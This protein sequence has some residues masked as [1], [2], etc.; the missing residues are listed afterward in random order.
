MADFML[1]D[2]Y[3]VLNAWPELVALK[4]NF[5][6]ARDKLVDILSDYGSYK[7]YNIIIV[8]DAHSIAGGSA[9]IEVVPGRLQV[10]FTKE[11]ETA[12]SYIEKLAYQLVRRGEAVYVVTSDWAQQLTILGVGAWRIPARELRS[13]VLKINRRLRNDY[14]ESPLNHRRREIG[15]CIDRNIMVKLDEMRRRH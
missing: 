11:S 13:E 9:I 6:H 10:V 5:E 12:D 4:E 7:G 14:Y 8:F 3:N 1:V 2:G 15:G